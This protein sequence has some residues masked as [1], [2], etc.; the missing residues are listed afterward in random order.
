MAN[1]DEGPRTVALNN[2]GKTEVLLDDK[3]PQC[4]MSEELEN[5]RRILEYIGD[6]PMEDKDN[7]VDW[8][9]QPSCCPP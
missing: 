2:P 7:E 1:R 4:D 6:W 5:P 9:L 8:V 3:L